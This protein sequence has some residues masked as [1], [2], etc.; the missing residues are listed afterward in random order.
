MMKEQL[1]AEV[2]RA[3]KGEFIT[4]EEL[5]KKSDEWLKRT[6]Y[7][8]WTSGIGRWNWPLKTESTAH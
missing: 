2:E 5:R 1:R 7:E 4:V 3:E 8:D 6:K